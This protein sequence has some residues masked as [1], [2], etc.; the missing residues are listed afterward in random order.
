M[1]ATS[2]GVVLRTAPSPSGRAPAPAWIVPNAP[3]RTFASDRFIARPIRIVSSGPDAAERREQRAVRELLPRVGDRT[4]ADELLELPERDQAARERDGADQR[5]EHDRE[6]HV[7]WDPAR[8]R[9]NPM[10]V[11]QRHE[12]RRA[13][14]D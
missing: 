5:R 14:A 13:A 12:R 1:I 11:R 7:E 4:A 2:S 10:E 3:K 9:C 6:P 8:V